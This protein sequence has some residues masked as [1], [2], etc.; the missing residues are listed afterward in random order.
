MMGI[1]VAR[2]TYH[3]LSSFA[4]IHYFLPTILSPRDLASFAAVVRNVKVYVP[5]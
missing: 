1:V 4:V 2:W 5:S 3:L